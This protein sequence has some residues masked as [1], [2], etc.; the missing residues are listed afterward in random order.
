MHILHD[1]L[2]KNFQGVFMKKAIRLF[3]IIALA[4]VIGF[5]MVSCKED[6]G[7]NSTYTFF[8]GESSTG[9]WSSNFGGSAPSD[10]NYTFGTKSKADLLAYCNTNYSEE[11]LTG[12]TLS[13][14]DDFL[15][16]GVEFGAI[17]SSDKNAILNK[18]KKDGF[19][20]F[21]LNDG[22]DILIIAVFK[23]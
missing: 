8:T 17:S 14:I 1:V 19:F 22:G 10:G 15:Q 12:L 2:L 23:E 11:K 7:S 13:D 3:G 9:V 21:G 6:D 18:L 4:A 20:L 5:S 16:E